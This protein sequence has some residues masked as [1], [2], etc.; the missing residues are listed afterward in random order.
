MLMIEMINI[1]MCQRYSVLFQQLLLAPGH[2]RQIR[3]DIG[4][5]RV[6]LAKTVATG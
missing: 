1:R 4:E 5:L 3:F 6:L 2:I